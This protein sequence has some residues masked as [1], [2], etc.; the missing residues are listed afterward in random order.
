MRNRSLVIQPSEDV[1]GAIQRSHPKLD[2]IF[3]LND[4]IR[5]EAMKGIGSYLS[6][7][8]FAFGLL[9]QKDHDDPDKPDGKKEISKVSK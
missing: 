8:Y 7:I 5:R 9:L 4:D 3:N 2:V 6:S 1:Y